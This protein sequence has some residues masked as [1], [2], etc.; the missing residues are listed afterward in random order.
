MNTSPPDQYISNIIAAVLNS[1][2]L[3]LI[4]HLSQGEYSATELSEISKLNQKDIHRHLEILETADLVKVVH[5]DE[6]Q[7]YHFNPNQI[8]Q[9]NRQY[10][11]QTSKPINL[12]GYD[13]SEDQKK[14][15]VQYTRDDGSLKMIPTKSKKIIAILEYVTGSF[16]KNIDY[17]EKQVN[18]ILEKFH[19][20]TTTLRRYLIDYGYLGRENDGSR[21]WRITP[22]TQGA[23]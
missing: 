18:E 14:I 5:R 9:F 22:E 7:F 4:A 6:Q 21:Y 2:R 19:P 1:E 3:T 23:R 11:T 12:S 15:V 20:D 13:L 16:E 17:N 10:F 8:E